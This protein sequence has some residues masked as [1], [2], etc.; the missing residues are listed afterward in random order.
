M[1]CWNTT[2]NLTNVAITYGEKVVAYIVNLDNILNNFSSPSDPATPFSF[3]VYGEYNDYGSVENIKETSTSRFIVDLFNKLLKK[4]SNNIELR[5]DSLEDILKE[6]LTIEKIFNL[7]RSGFKL[8]GKDLKI[9]MILDEVYQK[10]TKKDIYGDHYDD[11]IEQLD[12]LLTNY[13]STK[14]LLEKGVFEKVHEMR[15]IETQISELL[16]FNEYLNC[17]INFLEYFRFV[18]DIDK[19]DKEIICR[20]SVFEQKLYYLNKSWYPEI[21]G[22]QDHN[23]NEILELH[24]IVQKFIIK[25]KK[26]EEEEY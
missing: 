6:K 13:S 9:V 12:V 22:S 25:K 18:S 10:I 4:S 5:D 23:Y 26:L 24:S 21:S 8:N 16:S 14:K 3:P 19:T 20:H 11:H 17:K 1:G 2:C 15:K 7:I